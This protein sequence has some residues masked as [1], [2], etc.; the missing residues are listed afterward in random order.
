MKKPKK[1]DY[2]KRY[3]LRSKYLP[4]VAIESFDTLKEAKEYFKKRYRNSSN[5]NNEYEIYDLQLKKV[6]LT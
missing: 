1:A 2:I 4:E 3:I 6:V 5:I